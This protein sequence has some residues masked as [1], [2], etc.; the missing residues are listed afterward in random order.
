MQTVKKHIAINLP[1]VP[2]T[3]S[4]HVQWQML[5][6]TGKKQIKVRDAT[7]GFAGKFW[8]STATGAATLEWSGTE[9]GFTFVSNPA[10]T[11]TSYYAIFGHERNGAFFPQGDGGDDD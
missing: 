5:S 4:F 11:S 9:A 6:V 2:A 1:S 3:A 10:A 7:Q 8:Q